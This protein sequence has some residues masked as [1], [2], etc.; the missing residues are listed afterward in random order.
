MRTSRDDPYH[1]ELFEAF[2]ISRDINAKDDIVYLNLSSIGHILNVLRNIAAGWLLQ[3]NGDAS[4]KKC[5][6]TVALYSIGVNSLG[7]VNNPVCF[8]ITPETTD[9][10]ASR[11]PQGPGRCNTSK[12]HGHFNHQATAGSVSAMDSMQDLLPMLASRY[13]GATKRNV[14]RRLHSVHLSA[15]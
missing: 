8:A 9:G 13:C 5:R 7:H 3:L 10:R 12:R 2:V 15:P 4:Y 11:C 1:F 6:N 14:H